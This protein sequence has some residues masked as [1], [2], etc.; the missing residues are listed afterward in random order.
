[1]VIFLEKLDQVLKILS[2][3]LRLVNFPVKTDSFVRVFKVFGV[4]H[5]EHTQKKV[6]QTMVVVWVG[7]YIYTYPP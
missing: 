2:A 4:E 1:M 6:F 3:V 7:K 5:V